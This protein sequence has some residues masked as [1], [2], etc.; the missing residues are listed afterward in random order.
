LHWVV[1]AAAIALTA[2]LMPGVEIDGGL[3]SVL[4]IAV[5]FGLVNT[6]VGP[7]VK[8]LSIPLIAITL[9]LFLVIINAGLLALTAWISDSL[10]VDGFLTAIVASLVISVVT[11]VLTLVLGTARRSSANA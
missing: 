4:W 8:L 5:L 1:V 10:S 6:L 3:A 2:A 11:W 7:I 9:G